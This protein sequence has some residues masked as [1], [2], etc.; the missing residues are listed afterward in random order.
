MAEQY[1]VYGLGN[2]LVDVQYEVTPEFLDKLEIEKGVMTLVDEERQKVITAAINHPAHKQSSGGSAANS[3]IAIAHLGGRAY[4]ACKV[5][6]DELGEFY[7]QDLESADV[8]CNRAHRGDGVTPGLQAQD[9]RASFGELSRERRRVT[10]QPLGASLGTGGPRSSDAPQ[11]YAGHLAAVQP[12]GNLDFDRRAVDDAAHIR[13]HAVVGGHVVGATHKQPA[14]VIG[15]GE[16]AQ[17]H[18]GDDPS[19]P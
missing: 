1:D 18:G 11:P 6:N 16:R 2:A 3:M 8:A 7:L 12:V 5:G 4:Y 14:A 15:D 9:D 10:C 19:S 17:K 13:P